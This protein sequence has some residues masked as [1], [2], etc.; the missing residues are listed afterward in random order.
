MNSPEAT[1]RLAQLKELQ[2]KG[3]RCLVIDPQEQQSRVLDAPDHP[4]AKVRSRR[5]AGLPPEPTSV[6][7]NGRGD[8]TG[9]GEVADEG[10]N[11][12]IGHQNHGDFLADQMK[13]LTIG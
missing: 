2:V 5:M 4:A 9:R 11:L 10:R 1:K 12:V 3:R 6:T 13:M 7:D 8:P